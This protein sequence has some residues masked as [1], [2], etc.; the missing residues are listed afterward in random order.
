MKEHGSPWFWYYLHFNYCSIQQSDS[1]I[2]VFP[3]HFSVCFSGLLFNCI[4]S[5]WSLVAAKLPPLR[6]H[7]S[8][9]MSSGALEF[10]TD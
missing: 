8:I 2:S 7:Q 9:A 3:Q 1:G 5:S 6:C 4:E 10:S